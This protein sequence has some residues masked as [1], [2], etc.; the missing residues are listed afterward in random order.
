MAVLTKLPIETVLAITELA[1]GR[2]LAR[3]VAGPKHAAYADEEEALL[4]AELFLGEF[5][6]KAGASAQ[7]SFSLPDPAIELVHVE[8]ELPEGREVVG[9]PLSFAMPCVVLPHRRSRWVLVLPI[10][11]TVHVGRGEDLDEVVGTEAW[12]MLAAIEPDAWTRLGYFL[13]DEDRL[14]RLEVTLERR[15]PALSGQ[16]ALRKKLDRAQQK[17]RALSILGSVARRVRPDDVKEP[18]PVGFREPLA[19]L[20]ALL[21]GDERR[22]VLLVGEE[23]VGKSSLVRAWLRENERWLYATS[24]AQ[25]IAGMSLLGQWQERVRRVMEAAETLDAVLWFDDL[26][27]LLGQRNARLDLASAIRPW[28]DEGRVRIVGELTPEASDLFATRQ[29][30]LFSV[31][32]P[33]RVSPQDAKAARRALERCVAHAEAHAPDRPALKRD[34]IETVVELTDR[35]LPYR[36]FPGKAVRLYDELR[37]S[38]E[39]AH[40]ADRRALGREEVYRLFSVQTGI[41]EFLLRDDVAW[42][43]DRARALFAERLVGQEAAIDR[44]VEALA[45]VKAGLAPGDKPLASLLFVGPTGVGK[46]ALSRALAELLFGSASR[47]VR[48]DMSELSDPGAAERLLRGTDSDE[49]L[50]TSAVRQQPFGVILLDEIEKAHPSVFDL[51]LGVLGEGRLTDARGRTAFFHNAIIVMTS[52]LGTRHAARRV[53]IDPAPEDELARFTEA[54]E[55]HFRPELVNRIDR[56]VPFAPLTRAQI[57][58]VAELA[59]GRIA[60]RRG[61]TELALRLSVTERAFDRLAEDGYEEAYGARALRRQLEDSLVAPVARAL[62]PIGAG[63]RGARVVCRAIDEPPTEGRLLGTLEH[64]GV[65]IDVQ[66]GEAAGDA[67]GLGSLEEVA[68][69]RRSARRQLELPTVE[70]L[71][72]RRQYLLAELSYGKKKR[73]KASIEYGAEQKELHDVSARLSAVDRAAASIDAVEELV[74]ASTLAGEPAHELVE[75][76]VDAELAFREALLDL[77]LFREARHQAV[78]LVQEHDDARPLDRWVGGLLDAREALGWTVIGHVHGMRGPAGWPRERSWGPEVDAKTIAEHLAKREGPTSLILGV[79]GEHA[80]SLLALEAGLHRHLEPRPEVEQSTFV[81]RLLGAKQSS[82][83]PDLLDRGKLQPHP[84]PPK[85]QRRLLPA[86]RD[87]SRDE[88]LVDEKRARVEVGFDEYWARIRAVALTH[89]LELEKR[90]ADRALLYAAPLDTAAG[91]EDDA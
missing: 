70:E 68:K 11:L 22:S 45:V 54:V 15:G 86:V 74:L 89:L 1:S 6:R 50:L 35:F 3:P 80:G 33:L 21:S 7:A 69:R 5:L 14:A 84:V 56:I 85:S 37:S 83:T 65:A 90:F 41:P 59:A 79:R 39:R 49:G 87:V 64:G 17:R 81:V 66:P 53:G 18:E 82:V 27:D 88:T 26:R 40:L 31:M 28:L 13:G 60:L 46:T 32:H 34:A 2:V 43:A 42:R 55:G 44:I 62:G 24:G 77:L 10:G 4:Q 9:A 25:L 12:R 48:F 58:K 61:V 91:A 20:T 51:L 38:A 71:R 30:G 19:T 23:R 57:R 36:P 75:E 72:E 47:L 76:A 29:A 67:A 78:V 16:K 8:V 52:N 63:A 73:K